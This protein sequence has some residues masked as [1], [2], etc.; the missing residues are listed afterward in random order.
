MAAAGAFLRRLLDE[1]HVV[2]DDA[3]KARLDVQAADQPSKDGPAIDRELAMVPQHSSSI[4]LLKRDLLPYV[5]E[6]AFQVPEGYPLQRVHPGHGRKS[7]A[8]DG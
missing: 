4:P 7:V 5:G 6:G 2:A 3:L 8:G 1:V